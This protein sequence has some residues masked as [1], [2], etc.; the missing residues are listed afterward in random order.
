MST[1][2]LGGRELGAYTEWELYVRGEARRL[3]LGLRD[4]G[5]LMTWHRHEAQARWERDHPEEL[6]RILEGF[7]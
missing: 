7:T 5:K 2:Q 6:A 3:G 4:Y 1:M